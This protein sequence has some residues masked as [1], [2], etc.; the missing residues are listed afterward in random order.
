[1]GVEPVVGRAGA[2]N[3]VADDPDLCSAAPLT[4][5]E[6]ESYFGTLEPAAEM[7]ETSDGLW[8]D[9]ER[10]TARFF[11]A[12]ENGEPRHLVFVGYSFD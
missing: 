2:R 7:A 10:G 8:D 11:T 5:H 1:M 9:I 3:A 6:L 4:Q 12:Y